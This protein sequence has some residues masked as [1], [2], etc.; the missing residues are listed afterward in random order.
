MERVLGAAPTTP[1]VGSPGLTWLARKPRKSHRWQSIGGFVLLQRCFASQ[2]SA[3]GS[4]FSVM[5]SV[6][7]AISALRAVNSFHSSGTLSSW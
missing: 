1:V 5:T 7:A 4:F 2:L 6:V 3:S